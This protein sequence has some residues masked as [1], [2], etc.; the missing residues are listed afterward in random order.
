[1]A[2][3]AYTGFRTGGGKEEPL[4]NVQ[5][6]VDVESSDSEAGSDGAARRRPAV[7]KCVV[8]S[9]AGL[10]LALAIFC[11]SLSW[12][13]GTVHGHFAHP[14]GHA[15]ATYGEKVLIEPPTPPTTPAVAPSTV[16]ATPA[17]T[18][19]APLPRGEPAASLH[20]S[21]VPNPL[22]TQSL[23][24]PVADLHDGNVCGDSEELFG[25][26]CY[27]QCRL[28][29]GGQDAIRTS[30]WTC[31][32][33]HPCTTNQ[34]LGISARVACTGFAVAGDGSCPH[35]PGACL[36]DEEL[37][38]GVCYKKC[39]LLTSGAYPT[40]V[41]PATCCAGSGLDCLDFRKD[42][43][44]K[45]FAVGGGEAGMGACQ[46]D[47]ELVLGQCFKKCSLLTGNAYPLR[48][49]AATCCKADSRLPHKRGGVWRLGCLDPRNDK[50][51]AAFDTAGDARPGPVANARAHLPLRNLTEA[52]G[53]AA[54]MH[55]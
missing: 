43:T 13:G 26:L 30:P 32:E 42:Y 31:C 48:L 33:R 53:G 54:V 19:P 50:T 36:Q 22:A 49:A 4:R 9:L 37:F 45:E 52:A 18:T 28:L 38:L 8:A 47:E 14:A 35:K 24:G 12:M 25:G 5:E 16:A 11:F 2:A 40:R 39:G 20:S 44:S 21:P 3:L 7:Q 17:P 55:A 46:A 41:T 15:G 29:T 34:R 51:R 1:M 27:R 6:F 23:P 10:A